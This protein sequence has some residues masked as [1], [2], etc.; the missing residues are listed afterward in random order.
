MNVHSGGSVF[1]NQDDVQ[2][3]S[4]ESLYKGLF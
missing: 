4:K 2:V 1:Y 3:L